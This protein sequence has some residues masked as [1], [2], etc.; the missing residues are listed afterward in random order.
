MSQDKKQIEIYRRTGEQW[1]YI[2]LGANDSLHLSCIDLLLEMD[3][4]YEDVL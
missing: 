1:D 4:I 2:T 3:E